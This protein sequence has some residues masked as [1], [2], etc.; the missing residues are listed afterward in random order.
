MSEMTGMAAEIAAVIGEAQTLRL[1][2]AR[3]GTQI[4]IPK[5]AP[6]SQLA[7]LIGEADA[8]RLID[9]FG[10]GRMTLPTGAGRGVGGRRRQAM[11]MLRDGHSLREVALACDLS[12]RT[13]QNY[14]AELRAGHD[15]RQIDLPFDSPPRSG[16]D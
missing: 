1:L 16:A 3:G 15:P 8:D 11:R 7:D 13:V 2:Q 6:G 9:A 14:R 4:T 12:V 5:A 10:H